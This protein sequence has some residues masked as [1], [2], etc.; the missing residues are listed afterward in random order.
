M[1]L[2]GGPRSVS[3]RRGD[4]GGV[5]LPHARLFG[6]PATSGGTA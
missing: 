3:R 4:D 5:P 2:P 6:F 1:I